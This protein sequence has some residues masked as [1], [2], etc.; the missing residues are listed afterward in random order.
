MEKTFVN[1][2]EK[3]SLAEEKELGEL[4]EKCKFEVLPE[5]FVRKVKDPQLVAVGRSRVNYIF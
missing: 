1:G 3:Y 4:V 5:D 2:K